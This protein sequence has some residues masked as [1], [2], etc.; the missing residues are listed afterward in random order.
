MWRLTGGLAPADMRE[1]KGTAD[2]SDMTAVMAVVVMMRMDQAMDKSAGKAF[3]SVSRGFV[4]AVVGVC[5]EDGDR[6]RGRGV[7]M[8]N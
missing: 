7:P 5:F 6:W 4:T 1:W 8:R 2:L 3:V